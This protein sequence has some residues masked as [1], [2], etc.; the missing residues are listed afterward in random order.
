[1]GSD[2]ATLELLSNGAKA[3]R[4]SCLFYH[5][6]QV[7]NSAKITAA[8][9]IIHFKGWVEGGWKILLSIIKA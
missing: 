6:R 7:S 4:Y 5:L 1:M 2:M 9:L 8:D 3:S